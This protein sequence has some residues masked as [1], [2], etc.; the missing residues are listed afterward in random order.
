[1]PYETDLLY[2]IK[3]STEKELLKRMNSSLFLQLKLHCAKS[4]MKTIF[5][6]EIIFKQIQFRSDLQKENGKV[7]EITFSLLLCI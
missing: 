4:N 3:L 5:F 6:F 2:L 7:I 1:M